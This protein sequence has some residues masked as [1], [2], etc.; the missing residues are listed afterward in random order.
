MYC[1]FYGFTMRRRKSRPGAM[2]AETASKRG[3]RVTTRRPSSSIENF[4]MAFSWEL[5]KPLFLFGLPSTYLLAL[6]QGVFAVRASLGWPFAS[7]CW[8]LSYSYPLSLGVPWESSLRATLLL[9]NRRAVQVRRPSLM[10]DSPSPSSGGRVARQST[11]WS[12]VEG[13]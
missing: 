1:F 9:A 3:R 10:G 7:A 11:S 13:S 8:E 4:L 12:G 2:P 5:G 6:C